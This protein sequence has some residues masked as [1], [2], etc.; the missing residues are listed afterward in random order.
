MKKTSKIIFKGKSV[1]ESNEHIPLNKGDK[2]YFSMKMFHKETEKEFREKNSFFKKNIL[3]DYLND[4]KK[5]CNEFHIKHFKVKNISLSIT[6]NYDIHLLD[7]TK[8]LDIVQ[9]IEVVECTYWK[10]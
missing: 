2:F 10:F 9:S 8:G 7:N 1:F 4:I 3:E 6:K 5:N